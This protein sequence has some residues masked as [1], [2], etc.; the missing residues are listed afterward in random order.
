[1]KICI[2]KSLYESIII[3]NSKLKSIKDIKEKIIEIVGEE[4]VE[5]FEDIGNRKL[6]YDIKNEKEGHYIKIEYWAKATETVNELERYFRINSDILKFIT[7]KE[8]EAIIDNQEYNALLY[9][10]L[11]IYTENSWEDEPLDTDEVE[12]LSEILKAKLNLI[13]G[14]ITQEEYNNILQ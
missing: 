11:D 8:K 14:N 2:N 7:L 9:K 10:I 4:N 1:M 12:K 6:P 5:S 3:V 13:N